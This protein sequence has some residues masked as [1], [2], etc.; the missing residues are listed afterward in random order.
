MRLG[1]QRHGKNLLVQGLVRQPAAHDLRRH[2]RGRPGIHHILFWREGGIAAGTCFCWLLF[3]WVQRQLLFIRQQHFA[4]GIAI[5]DREWH[6]KVALARDAPVPSQVF[7]PLAIARLHVRRIPGDL[8]S[9]CQEILFEVEHADKPLLRDDVLDRRIAAFVY[10]HAL[11]DGLPI[12]QQ[13]LGIQRLDNTT[14]GLFYRQTSKVASHFCHSAI[15]PDSYFERELVGIP[16]F[17][18]GD[19]SEGAAHDRASAFLRVC[20][21]VREQRHF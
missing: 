12:E 13:P 2:R 21:R 20:L 6:T 19:I 16:P 15:S 14:P 17:H 9:C 8:L 18:V 1:T 5:P 3:G 4:A 10:A 7:H 11:L